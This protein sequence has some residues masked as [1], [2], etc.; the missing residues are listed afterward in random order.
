M[1]IFFSKW[2]CIIKHKKTPKEDYKAAPPS[3]STLISKRIE[4]MIEIE[5]VESK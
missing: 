4:G 1:S 3:L 5:E 2:E